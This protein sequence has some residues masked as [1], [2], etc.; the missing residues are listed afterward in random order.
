[1]RRWLLLL[2]V[3]CQSACSS[4]RVE[5]KSAQAVS[6]LFFK[7]LQ[8]HCIDSSPGA[9]ANAEDPKVKQKYFDRCLAESDSPR[10]STDHAREI[11][12]CMAAFGY[13]RNALIGTEESDESL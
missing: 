5:T 12:E 10:G 9:Q 1:M 4:Q 13:F 8:S 2:T 6:P 3:L 11:D 7:C